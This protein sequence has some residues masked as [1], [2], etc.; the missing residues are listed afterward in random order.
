MKRNPPKTEDIWEIDF[1]Q[2]LHAEKGMN[3]KTAKFLLTTG[4]LGRQ[5][6]LKILP[7]SC[8]MRFNQLMQV[9]ISLPLSLPNPHNLP[10]LCQNLANPL[11]PPQSRRHMC[12]PLNGSPLRALSGEAPKRSDH[13]SDLI[14][15]HQSYSIANWFTQYIFWEILPGFLRYRNPDMP[16]LGTLNYKFQISGF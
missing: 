10:S 7:Y 4:R 2:L 3:K 9:H 11:P 16:F 1:N 13:W 14:W 5:M 6:I 12:M 15:P 8:N